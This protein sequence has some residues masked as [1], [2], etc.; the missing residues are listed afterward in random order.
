MVLDETMAHACASKGLNG[1]TGDIS[2][3]FRKPAKI[4]TVLCSAGRILTE[5]RR[6]VMATAFL[7]AGTTKIAEAKA[8]FFVPT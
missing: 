3:R 5:R 2:I 8:T 4:G 7:T 6:V 1:F